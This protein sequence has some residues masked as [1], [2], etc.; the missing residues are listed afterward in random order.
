M[1]G[2]KGMKG[3]G[4]ARPGAGRPRKPAKLNDSDLLTKALEHGHPK[5][6]LLAVMADAGYDA[7]VR[8]DAAKALLPYTHARKGEAGKKEERQEAAGKAIG[9]KFAPAAAPRPANV[10]SLHEKG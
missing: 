4:G 10:H 6:F 1:A 7:R 9:G 2:I 5:A 8:V 3:S